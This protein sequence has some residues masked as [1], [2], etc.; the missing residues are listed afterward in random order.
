LDHS[1]VIW[2][3]LP[4]KELEAKVRQCVTNGICYQNLQDIHANRLY[5]M[6]NRQAMIDELRAK[7][8]QEAIKK[9]KEKK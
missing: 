9:M 1:H 5:A 8:V 2:E 4:K 7:Q 3:K 6:L